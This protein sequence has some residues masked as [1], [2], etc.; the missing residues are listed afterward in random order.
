MEGSVFV[1]SGEELTFPSAEIVALVETYSKQASWKRLSR[2]VICTELNDPEKISRI[3]GR[4]AYCRFGGRL[5]SIS[6]RIV[7]LVNNLDISAAEDGMSFA[8]RSESLDNEICGDVGGKIKERLHS[9][10]SLENPE[11]VFQVEVLDDGR[12]VLGVSTEGVKEFSWTSRRPRARRFFLPSAIYPKLS[13]LLV[14]LSRVKE[15]EYFLDPFCGT[16][17]LLIESSVM[18]IRTVGFDLTRWI[19]K[20]ARLNLEGFALDFESII[21]ADSTHSPFPLHRVDAIATD[22]PYGRA[23]STKGKDTA[24]IIREF[25]SA[26]AGELNSDKYCVLMH[27]SHVGLDHGSSFE[28]TEQHLLYVHRNLTRCISVLRRR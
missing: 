7:D 12:F 26:I 19:A 21:R 9:K 22:V 1:L 23:S 13:R 16:G 28:V 18:G 27:P 14:N 10:V 17:S 5:I 25:T 15:G 8:V 11:R 3:T 6:P 24:Q 20:G 2:R 4:A